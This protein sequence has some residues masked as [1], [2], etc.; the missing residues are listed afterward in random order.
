FKLIFLALLV[1]ALAVISGQTVLYQ[2]TDVLLATLLVSLVW[3]WLSV[4][5]L[6]F[7]RRLRQDR[8]Q[9]GGVVEQRLQLRSRFPIPR[10]WLELVDGGSLPNYHGGRVVDLGFGGRRAWNHDA[11]CRRRGLYQLGPAWLA[12]SDPF[13]LFHFTRRIGKPSSVLV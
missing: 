12:G 8:A 11:P 5:G 13:G 2:L 9:V 3:S 10:V 6:D 1:G 7:E 4:R